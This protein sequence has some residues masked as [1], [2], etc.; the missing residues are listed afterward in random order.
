MLSEAVLARRK[1]SE[2]RSARKFLDAREDAAA[3]HTTHVGSFANSSKSSVAFV[4]PEPPAWAETVRAEKSIAAM[5]ARCMM[6]SG[7]G[8]CIG[9]GA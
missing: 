4:V 7:A 5:V 3:V 2:S 8:Y 9:L 6:S 1:S